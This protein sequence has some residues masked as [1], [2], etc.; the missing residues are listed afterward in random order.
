MHDDACMSVFQKS[1]KI[2][3][4]NVATG[5]PMAGI[6]NEFEEESYVDHIYYC[7][8]SDG[9]IGSLLFHSASKASHNQGLVE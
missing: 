3:F 7:T 2:Q 6:A 1:S 4:A 5:H 8:S 9:G